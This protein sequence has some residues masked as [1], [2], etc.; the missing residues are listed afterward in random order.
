ME[1][2]S[3]TPTKSAQTVTPTNGK[4]L[5]SVAVA[6]IPSNYI[7]TADAT[8]EA[9]NILSEKTAYVNGTKV[10]GTMANNGAVSAK[11]DGLTTTSYVVPAGYTTGGTVSLTEDIENA[12]AAI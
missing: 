11:I 6:T 2:K 8:A 12:L 4:V 5:S 10:T 7:T 9:S 1:T 3:V